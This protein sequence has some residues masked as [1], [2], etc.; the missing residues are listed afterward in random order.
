M[1]FN[2]SLHGVKASQKQRII[3]IKLKLDV[4]RKL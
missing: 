2:S 4:K 1:P 3:A